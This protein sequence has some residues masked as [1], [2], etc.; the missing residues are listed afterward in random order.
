MLFMLPLTLRVHQNIINEDDHKGNIRFIKSIK[1][2]EALVNLKDITKNL[3][4]P[5]WVQKAVF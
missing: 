1:A 4:C 2:A 3:Y 5:L